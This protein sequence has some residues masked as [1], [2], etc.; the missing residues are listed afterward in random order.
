MALDVLGLITK[1][2]LLLGAMVVAVVVLLFV[3]MLKLQACWSLLSE[4]LIRGLP[5]RNV[6]ILNDVIYFP[7][8]QVDRVA[9]SNFCR[10]PGSC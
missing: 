9:E 2:F 10:E 3:L 8:S 5:V 6:S 1:I 4:Y 7:G